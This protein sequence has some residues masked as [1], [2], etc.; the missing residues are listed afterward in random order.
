MDTEPV[1]Q[2]KTAKQFRE[3]ERVQSYRLEQKLE[4]VFL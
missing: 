3:K 1:Y 2:W 4:G